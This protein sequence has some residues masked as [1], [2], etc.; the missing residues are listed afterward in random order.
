LEPYSDN[1][2][3]Q[4]VKS[5]NPDKLGLL[6]ERYNKILFG[7]FY[8]LTG[9]GGTSEDLVHNVFL[10]ILK[11][12]DKF[13]NEG[14][15]STWMFHIAHNIYADYYKK[16]KRMGYREEITEDNPGETLTIDED[17]E[18]DEQ[19]TILKKALQRLSDEYREVLVLSRYHEMKYREIADVLNLTESAVK[20][21]VFRAIKE[22]KKI[23]SQM[24]S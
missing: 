21:R 10:R 3:M 18:K 13:R 8:R 20:V 12:R 6:Y 11:Y 19:V 5:G 14:K 15:F 16:D 1:A 22:L 24:E 2:L 9:N 4:Q 7:F 17:A 23:Y